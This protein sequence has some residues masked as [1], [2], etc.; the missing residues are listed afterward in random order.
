MHPT[1]IKRTINAPNACS[2]FLSQSRS[3]CSRNAMATLCY[4]HCQYRIVAFFLF[5]PFSWWDY[6]RIMAQKV[7]NLESTGVQI[8]CHRKLISVIAEMCIA[9]PSAD[10]GCTHSTFIFVLSACGSATGHAL[11]WHYV[12]SDDY[13]SIISWS[14]TQPH[15]GPLPSV[16]V[17]FYWNFTRQHRPLG[18]E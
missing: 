2:I 13:K 14:M 9:A 8:T 10:C 4:L 6:Q 7:R 18:N 17:T 5:S 1:H 3:H 11:S 15:P 12:Q 16:T